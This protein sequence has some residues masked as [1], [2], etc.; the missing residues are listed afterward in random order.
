MKLPKMLV[1]VVGCGFLLLACS[2]GTASGEESLM[3]FTDASS[4]PDNV[5]DL[6]KTFDARADPLET[7]VVAEWNEDGV[8]CRYVTFKVG[9][10]KGADSRVGAFYTF[11]EGMKRGP[12]FVWAH[13]GGQRAERRRGQYF[14]QHGFATLDI[15]WGGREIVEGMEPHTDWGKIDPT[16]GPRFHAK[17]L[18][19]NF[20]ANLVPDEHT[21]D[22]VPSPRNS[23]WFL[24][25]L[26]GRRAITFLERQPEVDGGRIGFTGYSMGGT[27]TSM[28]AI[29]ERLRAV[30]PMVGGSGF[31]LDD[32]PGLPGSSKLRAH[33]HADLYRRTVDASS[34]W[35][36]VACPVL[37]LSASDDFHAIFDNVYKSMALVPH[38]NWRVSQKMHFNH[39]LGPEQWALLNLW[40]DRWLNNRQ[41]ELPAT[42][43]S[44][45]QQ[46]P[47]DGSAL[48]TVTP[49]AADSIVAVD[50]YYSHD[51]NARARF[52]KKAAADRRGRDWVARVEVRENLP[53]F[54][55]ANCTYPL[56]EPFETFQ[57][58][59]SRFSITSR[60][61]VLLP[62]VIRLE[63]LTRQ[64]RDVPVFE[65]FTQNGF[66]D[67]G[68]GPRGG[69]TTYKFRDPDLRTPPA[70]HALRVTLTPTRERLSYRF[71]IGKN[72]F[73]YGV[74]Q[75]AADYSA[76]RGVAVPGVR[77]I[78]LRPS[79]FT[80]R[81][82]RPMTDW[83]NV[84]T[85]TIDVYDPAAKASVDFSTATGESLVSRLEWVP[86]E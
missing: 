66:R 65:D 79:D 31:E 24:L 52:W 29:D 43:G 38:A 67:W 25:A 56:T 2:I 16:Q 82:K 23:N 63:A 20:K 22:A 13:G 27:I 61:H 9:T 80:D 8:V 21:V 19:K 69:L 74:R 37:F 5:N 7:E 78:L 84:V 30:A 47:G 4:V 77:E 32:L 41:I 34:Y 73:L 72:K 28:V 1:A 48:L 53:L 57:G 6:W 70:S 14:A 15:N 35:P 18:R 86:A 62:D 68:F 3:P 59:A 50:V 12:A 17:A 76:A 64:A 58:R 40:F 85:F 54:A 75:P 55:F 33:P 60:E 45:L 51:P 83:Q 71:R 81:D 26:T 11:P 36:H 49:A 44:S 39:S 42:P 46:E 10:F